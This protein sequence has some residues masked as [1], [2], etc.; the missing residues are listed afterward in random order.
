MRSSSKKSRPILALMCCG[1]FLTAF[2]IGGP[3]PAVAFGGFG[4]MGGFGRPA[5][6]MGG[7]SRAHM[8]APRHGAGRYVNRPSGGGN[9]V[10]TGPDGGRVPGHHRITGGGD[11]NP[12]SRGLE[13]PKGGGRNTVSLPGPGGDS[14]G[15]GVGIGPNPGP[16]FGGNNGGSGVPPR[17]ERRFVPNEVITAFSSSATPQ[18]IDQ[19]GRRYNLTRLESQRFA[20]VGNTFYRWRVDGRRPLG[21]VIGAIENERGV[22][23]AQPNYIFTLQDE[24]AKAASQ[25]P[26]DIAQYVLVKLQ[27][28]QAHQVATGKNIPVAVI[29]SEI[30][31]KHPDL[32][33][34]I[35][36]SFDALGGEDSPHQ[37]G[38]AMAGAIAAHGKLSGIAL[39]PELLAARAFSGASGEAKG[40]SFAIYKSLQWAADNGAR[41]V[42][43]SFA[44]PPDPGL[45][46]LLAAAYQ[47]GIV[48]IA[49]AGNA[50]PNAAPLYPAADPDVIAVTATDNNDKLFN[51][52]NRG[53]YIA[54]AAPGVEILALAPGNSYQITTGTSVAAAHVSG[55]AALLLEEKPS[56]K[57][58][59]IRTIIMS[60]AKPDGQRSDV[61]A[62]LANAYRAVVSLNG[63]KPVGEAA[64]GQPKQ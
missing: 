64:G 21:D 36:K 22:A 41:V 11:R 51:M 25:T 57:P 40:T 14:G 28:E 23:G 3:A 18:S 48:L 17:G 44:G 27:V 34:T 61:G 31:A 42:N 54:V 60:T 26:G 12:G 45:H 38:T 19:I 7:G 47:K 63:G 1:S 8:T 50:G 52:A 58:G 59:D 10:T 30:D 9:R 29:D 35:A 2:C 55:I 33:G 56:L 24:A 15:G 16:G 43:M 46:R 32:A 39:G 49:A 37:H 5:T 62:G 13:P 53:R 4:R 6:G 20:L